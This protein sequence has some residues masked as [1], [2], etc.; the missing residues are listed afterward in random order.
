MRNGFTLIELVFTVAILG[1]LTTLTFLSFLSA[2]QNQDFIAGRERA[3][4]VVRL[5]QARAL[6]G[7]GSAAW[8]AK[9]EETRIILFQGSSY[10]GAATTSAYG[11]PSSLE[12]VNIALQGGGQEITFSRLTGTTTKSGTFEVRVKAEPTKTVTI[13]VD[14]SGKV[15]ADAAAPDETGTRITDARHRA[16]TLGWSIENASTL[17]LTFSNPPDA[18][19]IKTITMVPPAPRLVFDWSEA[20]PVGTTTQTLRIHAVSITATTTTLHIDRDCRTNT[21]KVKVEIDAK[22]IATYE[23]DCATV[24][25]GLFGGTMT[26]P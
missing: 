26:E 14:P 2:K 21:K 25:L 17:Q 23:A 7:E 8:G 10:A 19:T 13:S 11:L 18:D 9:L 20:V 16:F 12:I 22:D 5:A 3:L 24:T 1:L 15:F 4:T 6:A